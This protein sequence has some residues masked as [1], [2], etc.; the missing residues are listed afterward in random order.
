[1]ANNLATVQHKKKFP[2]AETISD[3]RN[4]LSKIT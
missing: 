1:M 2:A 4:D 3:R